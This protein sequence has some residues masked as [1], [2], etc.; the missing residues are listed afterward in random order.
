MD[1]AY[2]ITEW[3]SCVCR[4]NT[5]PKEEVGYVYGFKRHFN[6]ISVKSWRSLLLVEEPVENHRPAASH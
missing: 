5:I 2:N 4:C 1:I 6:N 3:D